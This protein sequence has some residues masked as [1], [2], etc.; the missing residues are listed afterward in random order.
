MV[1][2]IQ[3]NPVNKQKRVNKIIQTLFLLAASKR[4]ASSKSEN[5]LSISKFISRIEINFWNFAPEGFEAEK[6]QM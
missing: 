2:E 3:Q 4:I 1:L 5:L 6:M